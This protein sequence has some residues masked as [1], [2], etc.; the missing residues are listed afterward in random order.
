[1]KEAVQLTE[2]WNLVHDGSPLPA[3]VP[4]CV[5]VDLLAAGLIPDPASD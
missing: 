1:M 4:G 3:Q 5:H 2:G